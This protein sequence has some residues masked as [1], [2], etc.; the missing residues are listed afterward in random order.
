[1]RL[2]FKWETYDIGERHACTCRIQYKWFKSL[3]LINLFADA[4]DFEQGGISSLDYS[5]APDHFEHDDMPT[6]YFA[7]FVNEENEPIEYSYAGDT[8]HDD[9][10]ALYNDLKERYASLHPDHHFNIMEIVDMEEQKNDVNYMMLTIA[11][12]LVVFGVIGSVVFAYKCIKINRK[13]KQLQLPKY[14]CP[15]A[16]I[17]SGFAVCVQ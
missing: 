13:E 3:N 6:S 11:L 5:Y 12:A 2:L 14:V 16:T 10:E 17:D 7:N 15:S 9:V 4:T 1:M 8:F